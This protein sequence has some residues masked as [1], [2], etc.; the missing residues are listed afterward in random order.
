M[1]GVLAILTGEDLAARG[2]G[3]VRA[4][5]PSKRADGTPGFKTPQPLLARDRVRMLGQAVAFVVAETVDAARDAAEAIAVDYA[6]LPALVAADDAL[7]PGAPAIW[8]DNPGNEAFTHEV[9]DPEAVAAGFARAAHVVRH[10]VC[11]NRVTGNPMEPRGCLAHY[12]PD[13]G[14]YTLRATIQSAH[15]I[16][17]ILAGQI[18]DLPQS[19]FRV[20]CDN[21][22]GGFGTRGGLPAGIRAGAVG[23]GGGGPAGQ[24][25]GGTGGV[26]GQRRTGPRRLRRRR[27]RARRR[28]PVSRAPHP[29]QGADRRLL[30]LRPQLRID[31][32]RVGRPGRRVPHAGDPRDGHRR[33]YQHHDQ[34]PVSRRRQARA[35]S[36]HRG[37]GRPRRARARRGPGPA[38]GGSTRSPRTSCRIRP[39]S[40]PPTI[41]ASSRPTRR[42][43]WRPAI[44]RVS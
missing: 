13:E 1:P 7:A 4:V 15:G 18:F 40:A 22:G 26:P 30:H 37:D 33:L 14:R 39:V 29:Q 34:R 17:A 8:H 20:V 27:P 23:I 24:M 28:V 32:H 3:T 16:R 43:R 44:T 31:S 19:R 25:G 10:R 38:A 6:P 12:D 11:V 21:M 41:A 42:V 2:L 5:V 35:L 9:G 36:R